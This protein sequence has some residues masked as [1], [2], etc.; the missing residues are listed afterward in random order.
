KN[1]NLK[2][3]G[4]IMRLKSTFKCSLI[5]KET[6]RFREGF[7]IFLCNKKKQ[8]FKSMNKAILL[9]I[10]DFISNLTP[11]FIYFLLRFVERINLYENNKLQ[12]QRHSCG[13][14]QRLFRLAE[15]SFSRHHLH[16]G[17]QSGKRPN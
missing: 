7:I 5:I 6:F 11:K 15:R 1:I 2:S 4:K 9:Q 16:S 3:G 12:C 13:F 10:R 14:Y 8:Q 17:K